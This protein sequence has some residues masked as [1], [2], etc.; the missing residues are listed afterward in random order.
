MKITKLNFSKKGNV[1]IYA[2]EEYLMSVPHEVFLKSKIKLNSCVTK[3]EVEEILRNSNNYNAKEKA[4]RLLSFRAHSKQELKNKIRRVSDDASAESAT[5]KMED[6]G[7][8]NDKNYA[9]TYA[10]ELFFR[11]FYSIKRV[12][13][14]LSKKGID[15]DI[16]LEVIDEISP[17]EEDILKTAF[18][19]K[20]YNKIKTEKDMNRAYMY[21]GRLGYSFSQIN[22]LFNSVDSDDY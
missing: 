8:I 15:K 16:I 3:E 6:L 11:K 13:Y 18:D 22:S 12:K 7:L 5:Q 10:K 14:E 17:D 21:F 2:D 4:F 20:F 1:V 9:L 19:R